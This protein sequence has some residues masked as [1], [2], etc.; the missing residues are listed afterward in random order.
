MKSRSNYC[1]SL[2]RV[3]YSCFSVKKR[4]PGAF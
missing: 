4:R 1:V 3:I 2:F